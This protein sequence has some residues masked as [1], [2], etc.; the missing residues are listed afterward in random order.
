MIANFEFG[1][2]CEMSIDVHDAVAWRD[3]HHQLA[4]AIQ[5]SIDVV[6]LELHLHRVAQSKKNFAKTKEESPTNAKCKA[7]SVFPSA[8]EELTPRSLVCCC[9]SSVALSGCS[10]VSLLT[11]DDDDDDEADDDDDETDDIDGNLGSDGVDVDDDVAL[12]CVV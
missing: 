7:S 11:A 1:H 10:G 8:A 9:G 5:V 6:T 4:G 12:S 2:R 3:E